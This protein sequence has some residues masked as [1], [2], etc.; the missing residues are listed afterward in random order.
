MTTSDKG[1]Q[2]HSGHYAMVNLFGQKVPNPI[3]AIK[4]ISVTT[5]DGENSANRSSCQKI[6]VEF[7]L[8]SKAFED[9]DACL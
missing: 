6:E 9:K 5:T 2:K 1:S 3:M 4:K 7:F 8:S